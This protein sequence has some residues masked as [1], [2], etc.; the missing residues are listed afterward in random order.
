MSDEVNYSTKRQDLKAFAGTIRQ[1]VSELYQK[2]APDSVKRRRN[3]DKRKLSDADVIALAILGELL[4]IDSER[5][6]FGFAERNL[7][8]VFGQ[9]CDRTRYN[10]S[11]RNLIHV[12][13]A[14][15]REI[16]AR[17]PQ[18]EVGI[19]DSCP[20]P[21][22]K[23]GRAAFHKTFRGYGASY[24]YC[25]SK[26]EWYYGY[27]LH[28]VTDKSGL[29]TRF[30]LT[31]A[32]VDDRAVAEELSD[33]SGFSVLL[34][35]KGYVGARLS[36]AKLI[37]LE[38]KNAKN[39][40]LSDEQRKTVFKTRRKIETTLSQMTDTLNL[41]KVRARSFW[42]LCTTV[43]LKILAFLTAVF[44]NFLY[45]RKNVFKIKQ[46]IFY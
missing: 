15:Q 27:K 35:D 24:G 14:I 6:W 25:A 29:P 26:K 30:T 5:C 33:M 45:G 43:F 38:R 10:R 37:A 42:G 2:V 16:A 34:G 11:K 3:I 1:I 23:F 7:T 31:G 12:I 22:C 32:N 21:V 41:Q 28:L 39:P 20:L 46:L 40:S 8:E 9:F 18:S 44:I 36:G 13:G 19:I 17:L 4:G